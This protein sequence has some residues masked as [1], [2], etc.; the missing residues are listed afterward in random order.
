MKVEEGK[1]ITLEYTITTEKGELIES[2]AGRGGPLVFPFGKSGLIPGLDEALIGMSKG[3]EKEFELAPEKAFG[4]VDSGPTID[5]PKSRLP[6]D[7]DIEVGSMF[8]ADMAGNNQTVKMCVLENHP[9]DVKVRLIHPLAGKTIC[10]KA[11]VVEIA[12]G[13]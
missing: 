4:T 7:I 1:T 3:E 9:E 10:I 6:E 8:E 12:D 5:V 2:S 13:V 11:K